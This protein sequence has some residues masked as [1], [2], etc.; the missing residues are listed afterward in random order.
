MDMVRVR[1]EQFIAFGYDPVSK[2]LRVEFEAA[3]YTY[4]DVPVH[5]YDAFKHA[6]SKT[7]FYNRHIRKY[8]CRVG[9]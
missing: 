7:F 2:E 4:T 3:F 9:F 1:R 6:H 5:V 8:P